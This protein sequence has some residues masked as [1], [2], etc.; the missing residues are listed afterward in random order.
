MIVARFRMSWGQKK[1]RSPGAEGG[2][3]MLGWLDRYQPLAPG[4]RVVMVIMVVIMKP[5]PRTPKATPKARS[6]VRVETSR[7]I[8]L[9]S[10]WDPICVRGDHKRQR[11][12][13]GLLWI[14]VP[15]CQR[16][17]QKGYKH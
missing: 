1:A 16:S 3:E 4:N 8:T 7:C 10:G 17:L 6:A 2:P 14:F 13:E 15:R 5:P 9:P 12:S 11:V